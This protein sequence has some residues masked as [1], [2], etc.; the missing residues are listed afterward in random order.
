MSAKAIN[1]LPD[2]AF[3]HIEP[4]GKK[5]AGGKTTPRSLRHYPVH[6]KA[7]AD[8]AAARA[9]A[10]DDDI[11]HKAMPAIKAAQKKFGSRD[12]GKLAEPAITKGED[13]TVEVE[14]DGELRKVT[15]PDGWTRKAAEPD[16]TKDIDPA[17]QDGG[18]EA[19]M[20]QP[21]AAIGDG[22]QPRDD[23]VLTGDEAQHVGPLQQVIAGIKQL[24]AQELAEDELEFD[25]IAWLS[26]IGMDIA[27]WARG[28]QYETADA[29][30]ARAVLGDML[31]KAEAEPDI[32]KRRTFY[33]AEHRAAIQAAINALQMQAPQGSRRRRASTAGPPPAPRIRATLSHGI[34]PPTARRRRTPPSARQA[35]CPS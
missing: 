3:A 19:T 13:R 24:I 15:L 20:M 11:A 12:D 6:D 5:D 31:T 7:H 9:A 8:N 14:I 35:A 30:I 1:D 34:P 23:I 16:E 28:E 26:G 33:T 18:V 10:A 4:G 17:S 27:A 29:I 21:E 2:S 32:T 22:E 25:C